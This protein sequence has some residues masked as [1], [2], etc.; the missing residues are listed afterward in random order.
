MFIKINNSIKI[1]HGPWD[2]SPNTEE[3][4]RDRE[5][6][7]HSKEITKKLSEYLGITLVLKQLPMESC[8][9]NSPLETPEDEKH[10]RHY[11]GRVLQVPDSILHLLQPYTEYNNGM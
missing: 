9:I 4:L 1:Y 5:G 3:H 8:Q 6:M 7:F 11:V 2:N 10:T